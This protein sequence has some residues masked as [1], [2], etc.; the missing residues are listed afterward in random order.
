MKQ[1]CEIYCGNLESHSTGIWMKRK[2]KQTLICQKPSHAWWGVSVAASLSAVLI[3]PARSTNENLR[4][5]TG[6]ISPLYLSSRPR[7]HNAVRDHFNR[8]GQKGKAWIYRPGRQREGHFSFMRN[9]E[10]LPLLCLSFNN[11]L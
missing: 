8:A 10:L 7:S 5:K 11:S 6:S 3:H 1:L 2:T 9:V 4:H